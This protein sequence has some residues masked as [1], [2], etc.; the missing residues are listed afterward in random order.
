MFAHAM[1]D[2]FAAAVPEQ[3]QQTGHEAIVYATLP[4]LTVCVYA[5]KPGTFVK[6]IWRA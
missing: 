5:E 2:P 1:T 4:V 3:R 6:Q